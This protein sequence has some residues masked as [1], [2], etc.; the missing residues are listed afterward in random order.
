MVIN[1]FYII[2][3]VTGYIKKS[4]FGGDL[5][6]LYEP[7]VFDEFPFSTLNTGCIKLNNG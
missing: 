4:F 3:L 2:L 6:T 1:N 7:H 5:L